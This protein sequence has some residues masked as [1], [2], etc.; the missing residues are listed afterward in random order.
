MVGGVFLRILPSGTFIFLVSNLLIFAY[1]LLVVLIILGVHFGDPGV[2]GRGP[3]LHVQFTS[4]LDMQGGGG[5][6]VPFVIYFFVFLCGA[7]VYF[8]FVIYLFVLFFFVV[9]LFIVLRS[10]CPSP[11]LA[12][13]D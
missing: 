8:P 9:L 3:R 5:V 7:I 2:V 6:S 13:G 1:I 11:P 12:A 4:A 10:I